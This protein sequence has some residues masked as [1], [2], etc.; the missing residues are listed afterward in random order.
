RFAAFERLQ[1]C[2]PE[3]GHIIGMEALEA[4]DI[5]SYL[6]EAEARVVEHELIRADNSSIRVQDGDGVR[7]GIDCPPKLFV[8]VGEIMSARHRLV[9]LL[10]EEDVLALDL[11]V[12]MRVL[13]RDGGLGRQQRKKPD[14]GRREDAGGEGVLE[15]ER[16]NES[17]LLDEGQAQQ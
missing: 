9:E 1:A 7:N 3:P 16:A 6:F 17:A 4:S 10:T 11:R 14:P 8:V 13:Q 2:F 15:V 12:E 5:G